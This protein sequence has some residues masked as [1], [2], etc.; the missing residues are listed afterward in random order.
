MHILLTIIAFVVIFS[1]LVLVHEMGHFLMAKRAGIKVMEFGFGLP[2]RIW[3]KK[4]GETIYSLNWIPFG[5]FVRMM[6]EDSKSKLMLKNKRSFIAQTPRTRFLVLVAGVTM[7]FILAWIL[8]TAGYTVGM[9]PLL[10]PDDVLNAVDSGQVVMKEGL[11]VKEIEPLTIAAKL[12][13]KSGDVLYSIDGKVVGYEDVAKLFVVPEGAYKFIRDGVFFDYQVNKVDVPL[14]YKAENFG[15]KFYDVVPFPRVKIVNLSDSSSA[16]VAGLRNG[17]AVLKI[18]GSQVYD[19]DQFYQKLGGAEQ[20]EMEVYR[21]GLTQ[22]ISFNTEALRKVIISEVLPKTPAAKANLRSGDIIL[23]IEGE[24]KFAPED[25]ISYVK[26]NLSKTLAFFIE[27]DGQTASYYIKPSTEG[28]IGVFLSQ[29]DIYG[30]GQVLGAYNAILSSSIMEIK[31]EKY[32]IYVSAYKSFYEMV[33]MS[34]LTAVMFTDFIVNLVKTQTVAEDV[35]GPVG[36][37][38]MTSVFVDEG[39][40]S[41]LRF[42]ALLSLSL[43]V[44]NI[45]P[46]PAL[47]GGRLIFVLFELIF[48]RRFNQKLEAIIHTIGYCLI[49]LL[50]LAVT[51][52]DIE[53]IVLSW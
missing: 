26:T 43:A 1:V 27:R 50:I 18:N 52:S 23:S 46:L 21:E 47:D 2:P 20:I 7:N 29:L 40:V 13:I 4:K 36:I 6:G 22:K 37:A 32:P 35:A 17:D 53:K 12:G 10:L 34:K 45:L 30:K 31:N 11:A 49:I 3:G 15:I 16:Y 24:K 38:R 19:T 51:Y 33:R 48:A 25:V 44:I 5:G 28:R 41:L 39:L 42:M 9:Q 8:L 14:N